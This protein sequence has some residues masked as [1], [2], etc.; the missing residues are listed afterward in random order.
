[1]ALD[2]EY[3][4]MY[5]SYYVKGIGHI[6]EKQAGD[7]SGWIYKVNGLSPNMG[8]SSYKLSEGDTITWAY[9]CDGKTT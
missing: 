1:M 6:Y 8:A 9:T 2:A 4:A 3:T 7:M 5:K